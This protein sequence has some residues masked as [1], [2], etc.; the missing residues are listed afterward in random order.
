MNPLSHHKGGKLMRF[1]SLGLVFGRGEA[2][3]A[4]FIVI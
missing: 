4:I 3:G 1:S 2:L